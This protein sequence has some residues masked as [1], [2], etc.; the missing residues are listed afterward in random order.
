MT[1]KKKKA[2]V[3]PARGFATTSVASKPKP[4]KRSDKAE[5]EPT[6]GAQAESVSGNESESQN[7]AKQLPTKQLHNSEKDIYNLTPGE[8]EDQLER[9]DLQL[10][11]EKHAAKVTKDSARQISKVQTD[12]RVLRAQSQYL[13]TEQWLPDE[14]VQEIIEFARKE[15]REE[16][17]SNH[18]LSAK[19]ISEEDTVFRLWSLLRTLSNLGIPKARTF[20]LFNTL[21]RSKELKPDNGSHVWGFRESLDILSLDEGELHLP[22][23]DGRRVQSEVVTENTII[24]G[25]KHCRYHTTYHL[26]P[27]LPFDFGLH[28]FAL[29]FRV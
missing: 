20:E 14:L 19:I 17:Q 1:K 2:P 27:V 3:N 28:V 18:A 26:R 6:G 7:H 9:D 13:G 23:Y 25:K 24:E 15:T 29:I 8:L 21:L 12:C 11:V 4:E 22:G 16:D 10:F 5:S